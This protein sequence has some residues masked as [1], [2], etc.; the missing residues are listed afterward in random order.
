MSSTSPLRIGVLIVPPVQLLDVSSVD[1][2]GML[3]KEYLEACSL[4]APLLALGIPVEIHYISEA[5]PGIVAECTANARLRVTADL[6]DEVA[7]AGKI[8]ILMIPGPDPAIVPSIKVQD[9]IRSHVNTTS[10]IMTVCTGIFPAAYSGILKGKHATGPRAPVQGLK[11]KFPDT[12][13]EEKR[14]VRDGNIWCSG[15][16]LPSFPL[17]CLCFSLFSSDWVI[18]FLPPVMHYLF[19]SSALST[20]FLVAV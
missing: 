7:S 15:T 13:W 17:L 9:F 20:G 1:L 14:W 6:E 5:G 8:D 4:P 10:A 11:T 3:T 18:D 2:F 19:L 12:K 16:L